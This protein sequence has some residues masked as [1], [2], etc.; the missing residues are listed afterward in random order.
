MKPTNVNLLHAMT[1]LRELH[2][3]GVRRVVIS[4][5]SRST[6]LA[7]A[8]LSHDRLQTFT[9]TDERSAGFFALGLSKADHS[10]A[11]LICTSGTAAANYFP[12]VIE[13]S[14]A[15]V[16]LIVLTA[17]RPANL[18]GSGA[19]QTI[20]QVNLYG[21]YPRF[22]AD[23]P[24]AH[25]A[26][27][28]IRTIR[29]IAADAY[30]AAT[31]FP[32]GPVHLNIPFAEPLAPI[33]QDEES[34]ATVWEQAWRDPIPLHIAKTRVLSPTEF[35][36]ISE[37][38]RGAFCGLIVA[39]PDAARSLA[40]AEA[41]FH[42]SRK[43][44]WPILADVASGLRF[45]S[46]PVV[47]YYDIFLR[48]ESLTSLAPDVVLA[49][50]AHPVSKV[51]Q[52]Y[53]QQHASAHTI[54][55]RTHHLPQD[56]FRLAR[57]FVD[58][59]VRTFCEAL[60]GEIYASRD[61]LLLDPFQRAASCIRTAREGAPPAELCEASF[62]LSALRTLPDNSQLVLANSLSVRYADTLCAAE[63]RACA[64]FSMRGANGIDGTLSHAAG[65]AAASDKPTL[66]ITGDLAFLHD[67]CGLHAVA[68]FA[69]NLRIL[70]LNND[71]GGIFHFL[72]MAD[73]ETP[74]QFE[75]IHGTPH[76]ADFAAACRMFHVKHLVV[77]SPDR[78][79]F[80][81][82]ANSVQVIEVHI[83]RVQNHRVYSAWLKRLTE[84]S[85]TL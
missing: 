66:L 14:Q 54:R 25:S 36:T 53:L 12:A 6:P 32:A 33:A 50:G 41:L 17:D 15:D 2:E 80:Q 47:P 40:D 57:T 28:H 59:D 85:R 42:L 83:S 23:L 21:G 61:S 13:A 46:P 10:P 73:A 71:G 79:L 63:G 51:L 56:P 78:L 4:P 45:F 69:P 82:D 81:D 67:I 29:K 74:E 52:N 24:A 27:A 5:G 55:V 11:V 1:L 44:G 37:I 8:A 68:R 76:D 18:R 60:A 35:A 65:I 84:A 58:T 70:L 20:N 64:V 19:P 31:D 26:V 39:G 72:P 16:P 7:Y 34:V 38:V 9:L 48:E 30:Q 43:L 22:F 77:E 75:A 3:R 62:V 49:F